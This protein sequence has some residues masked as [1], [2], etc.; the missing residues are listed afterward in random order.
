[1]LHNHLKLR[2]SIRNH[3]SDFSYTL[4][5]IYDIRSFGLFS[6][7]K[8]YSN[9]MDYILINDDSEV[10]IKLVNTDNRPKHQYHPFI[11]FFSFKES[12]LPTL[13]D[14][15]KITFSIDEPFSDPIQEEMSL[16]HFLN[17][18]SR[19]INKLKTTKNINLLKII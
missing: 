3:F 4:K 1:M 7:T 9:I 12:D 15:G 6:K 14:G 16:D 5:H 13:L 10:C 11:V 19:I 17:S 8:H 18:L 2:T